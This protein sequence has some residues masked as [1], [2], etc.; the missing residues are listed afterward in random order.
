MPP[1]SR[2][3]RGDL[4]TRSVSIGSFLS[5]PKGAQARRFHGYNLLLS[6]GKLPDFRIYIF[7][8]FRHLE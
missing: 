2:E 7:W 8:M 6:L 4:A 5:Q 1:T 3:R